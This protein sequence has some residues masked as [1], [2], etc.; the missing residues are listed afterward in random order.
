GH[1]LERADFIGAEVGVGGIAVPGRGGRQV[2]RPFVGAKGKDQGANEQQDQKSRMPRQLQP[3]MRGPKA[4]R[5]P[6]LWYSGPLVLFRFHR[7]G[8]R[9]FQTCSATMAWPAA[10]G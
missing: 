3:P 7:S 5:V 8:R 1:R 9:T 4:G 6:V 10:L 2:R